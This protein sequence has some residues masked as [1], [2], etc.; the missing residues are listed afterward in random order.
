MMNEI[1]QEIQELKTQQLAFNN[2]MLENGKQNEMIFAVLKELL[3]E[4]QKEKGKDGL[5]EVVEN[6]LVKLDVL[7][8]KLDGVEGK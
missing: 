4:L 1:L 2:M 6:I 5:K 8:G 7:I 3:S